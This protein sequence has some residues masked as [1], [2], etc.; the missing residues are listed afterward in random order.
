MYDTA[1]EYLVYR[2]HPRCSSQLVAIE[3]SD[4][5]TGLALSAM[6][7]V[8]CSSSGTWIANDVASWAAL[9]WE[10]ASFA[11]LASGARY[12]KHV[13]VAKRRLAN[14]IFS[15]ITSII[16][17]NTTLPRRTIYQV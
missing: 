7:H 15:S 17:L 3:I 11:A 5:H 12:A 13:A 4:M 6:Q 14:F 9:A 10:I 1:I 16:F 2:Q 8:V